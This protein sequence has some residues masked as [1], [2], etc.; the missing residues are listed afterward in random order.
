MILVF[1]TLLIALS[2]VFILSGRYSSFS[3]IAV[4]FAT[5]GKQTYAATKID[6]RYITGL[7]PITKLCCYIFK[8][9]Y[10]GFITGLSNVIRQKVFIISTPKVLGS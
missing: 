8:D 3:L 6:L 2:I 10:S 7:K 4:Y 1:L 9:T 5:K